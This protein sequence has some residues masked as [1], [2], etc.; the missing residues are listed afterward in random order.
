MTT[1]TT[2][3]KTSYSLQHV[4]VG[5]LSCALLNSYL[6]ILSMATSLYDITANLVEQ[7]A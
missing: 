7:T 3:I 6:S 4:T 5:L 2:M 1:M